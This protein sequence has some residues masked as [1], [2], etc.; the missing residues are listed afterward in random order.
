MGDLQNYFALPS[1]E[2]N[3]FSLSY[4]KDRKTLEG[5][6]AEEERRAQLHKIPLP[7]E[8]DKL[9]IWDILEWARYPITNMLYTTA[10]EAKDNDL[11][12]EDIGKILKSAVYGAILKERKNTEDVI[13]VLYPNLKPW[14]Y[15]V[16]GVAGDILTNPV[17]WLTFGGAKVG[18]KGLKIAAAGRKAAEGVSMGIAKKGAKAAGIVAKEGVESTALKVFEKSVIAKWGGRNFDEAVKLAKRATYAKYT[19]PGLNLRVPFTN[20]SKQIIPGTRAEL[21]AGAL[22]KIG[23]PEKV[24]RA[25]RELPVRLGSLAPVKSFKNMFVP[26]SELG[27]FKEAHG[28]EVFQKGR[29]GLKA[30]LVGNSMNEVF[31]DLKQVY[32]KPTK[33]IQTILGAG[34][35]GKGMYWKRDKLL[36]Y[37]SSR[38]QAGKSVADELKGVQGKLRKVLDTQWDELVK[39]GLLK[40]EQ[41]I[42]EYFPRYY[43]NQKTNEIAVLN[44]PRQSVEARFLKHR[45]FKTDAE[46]RKF[47]FEPKKAV[48]SLR[49]Y[50]DSVNKTLTSYDT[51]GEMVR[52]Y[53]HM[54]KEAPYKLPPGWTA[55]RHK[56]FDKWVV[57]TDI[58]N[59]LNKIDLVLTQEN[60]L[61]KLMGFA[62]NIQN[63]W[64]K[65]ATVFWPG[66]HFRNEASNIWTLAFKDG[67]GPRQVKNLGKAVKIFKNPYSD[68]L[69]EIFDPIAKKY[70]KKPIRLVYESLRKHNIHTGGFLATELGD[71]LGRPTL[72]QKAAEAQ[73]GALSALAKVE[74]GA[75]KFATKTGSFFENTARISSALNDLEKG[76]PW[77]EVARRVNLAFIN[78]ADITEVEK[79][80]RKVIPFWT[81]LRGNLTNQLT[82]IVTDPG[83]YS[84]FTSKPLRAINW[85]KD[86]TKQYMPEWMK[87]GMYVQPFGMKYQGKPLMLNPNLPFQDIG[88]IA[89]NQPGRSIGRMLGE[90]MSPFIKTPAELALNKSYFLNRPIAYSKSDTEKAPTLL[91]PIIATFPEPMRKRLGIVKTERGWEMP[92]KWTYTLMSLIPQ[93]KLGQPLEYLA[94]PNVPAYRKETAP[95]DI[96]ART[97][98][99]KFKPLDV[100][101]YKNRYLTDKLRELKELNRKYIM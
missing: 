78:Y 13:R 42:P 53:G 60:D 55:I 4:G 32:D 15:A 2:Q 64:K 68:E 37:I 54:A 71:F 51:I 46:A 85:A 62:N 98:G 26:G 56:G 75:T 34:G 5:Q 97:T 69:I 40:K 101:Y 89:L 28:I 21:A 9:R 93:M 79:G 49:I 67:V 16:F 87:E 14:Q 50:L 94:R 18:A 7:G 66:F 30:E 38:T 20:L 76:L 8:K 63:V 41:Y 57:P 80:L 92:A 22:Q 83:K 90:R 39:R 100:E 23:M 17:T 11:G 35:T 45:V 24:V 19:K 47:G 52:K 33:T 10:V 58:G 48:D 29:G 86:E 72:L 27:P 84:M 82:Y 25:T 73:G 59:V 70:V 95:F 81:W 3:P 74:S 31:G 12:F 88:Q 61:R 99:I 36:E 91:E 65:S 43:I 6:I 96:G 77:K 44:V 1:P